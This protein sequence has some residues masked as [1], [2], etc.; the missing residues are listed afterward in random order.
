MLFA[1]SSDYKYHVGGSLPLYAPSYVKRQA[2]EELYQA[3]LNGEFCYVLN[4]RQMGKSS[5]RVQTMA[6]LQAAEVRCGV[7]DLT[8]IGTQQITPEQWYAS[9][10][11]SLAG[12][13]QLDL[14]I[15]TWWRER[16]D[17]SFVSRFGQFLETLLFTCGNQS[18]VIFIDEIDSVLGLPF[19]VDDFFALIRSCY[20]RR[21]EFSAY[22]RLTFALLGVA[23]PAD[24]IA[25]KSRTPFNIGRAIQLQGFQFP[26]ALPLLPGLKQASP[27]PEALL[28]QILLWTSG[29]PFLTQK[30]CQLVV[31]NSTE[32]R[33]NTQPSAHAYAASY[34]LQNG[35]DRLVHAHII[36]NWEAQDEPEHLKTIRDRLLHDEQRAGRLLGLYQQ[37]FSSK[38]NGRTAESTDA[39]NS[40]STG[41]PISSTSSHFLA[42]GIPV[43]NSRD[44]TELVL[45]GLVEKRDGWL[46]VKNPIYQSVFNQAWVAKQLS[47]LRPYSQALNAWIASNY[48]DESRLLRGQALQDMLSWA[49]GKSLGDLDYRFLA[50]SQELDHREIQKTL[51][52]D[53]ARE[54]EARLAAE[55]KQ[56][57]YER[58]SAKRQRFLLGLV[59]VA[60]LVVITLGVITSFQYQQA[61]LGEVRAIAASS[62][63]LFASNQKLDALLAAVKAKHTLQKLGTADS[64][65]ES[66]VEQVLRQSVYG[67]IEQNRLSGHQGEVRGVT[68]SRDSKYLITTSA[69]KTVKLWRQDGALLRT[70]NGHLGEVWGV[71]ISRDEKFIAT[72]SWDKTV[73]LWQM[74]G[75]LLRTFTQHNARANNVA[76]SPDGQLIAS[77]GADRRIILWRPDGTVIRTLEG[78]QDEVWG[79]AFSPDGQTIASGSWDKTIKLWRL[80]GTLIRTLEGHRDRVNAVAFSPDGRMLASGAADS[81]VKLWQVKDGTEL[82]TLDGHSDWVWSVAFSPDSQ[83]IASGSWDKTVKLWRTDGTPVL[84]LAGHGD[85]VRN[86]AFSPDGQVLA[87]A[88]QDETVKL[89]QLHS[90]ILTVL[91]GHSAPVIRVAVSQGNSAPTIV[92]S[93]EDKTIRFWNLNGDLLKTLKGHQSSVIGIA[94]SPDGKMLAS[95]S[96]DHT[97]KLWTIE[98][99][100]L[101]TIAAHDSEVYEVRFSPDGKQ[102]ASAGADNTMK[103]WSRDGTLLHTFTGHSEPVWGVA[104][105]PDGRTL[106][107]SSID[108]TIKLWSRDGRLLK[109]LQGHRGAVWSITFSPDGQTLAS[110]SGDGT[111]KLWNRGGKLLKTLGSTEGMAMYVAFSPDG[112]WLAS[113]GLDG[114]VRLWNQDGTLLVTLKGHQSGVSG[115]AFTSDSQ[116]L[117]ST[118]L[119]KTLIVWNLE[120]DINLNTVLTEG[121]R[122][123][124]NYLKTNIEVQDR[125]VC[126]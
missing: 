92:S 80:D 88:S 24:L 63:A 99:T 13:F 40:N 20:N 102:F 58:R 3:L 91:R 90:P 100:L 46:R 74:N 86:V 77:V 61:V 59:S 75:T 62:Q 85:R 78:H 109:T 60:L 51:E 43:S 38:G 64:A 72:A 45:S 65:S 41:D 7:L 76:I 96:A 30:L 124:Q 15:R 1:H 21:A 19:S 50:A 108:S 42:V 56:L 118:S 113:T 22:H 5:L 48:Q 69:D 31:Q 121:C 54:A 81:T 107:S 49:Q 84:T 34:N 35:L 120:R 25:D 119:D 83:F 37:I 52:A 47:Y 104:F 53:R 16:S 95:G 122:W 8:G 97:I 66:Q 10:A 12:S 98:G 28:H 73:K 4:A 125:K 123:L 116:H 29:Q 111:V 112:R 71:D 70:F 26:E 57:A 55:Q 18:I 93:S 68:F 6:R 110:A 11:A 87:S 9:V 2:D 14:D 36:D 23:T 79:V 67:A 33:F 103:L 39:K 126:Q 89:W 114:A 101:R 106:A 105:S 44:Q 94:I 17:L 115:V 32:F 82:N 27:N 117:I